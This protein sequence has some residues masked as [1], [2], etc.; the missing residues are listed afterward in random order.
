MRNNNDF[1]FVIIPPIMNS[2]FDDVEHRILSPLSCLREFDNHWMLEF[3]LPL[4]NKKDI[5]IT[6]DQNTVNIEAKLREEYFE[7]KLGNITKFEYFKKSTSLP[8]KINN[9]KTTAKFQKGRLVIKIPKKVIGHT[10]KI[11]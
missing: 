9:K 6:F 2:L 3:D 11:T 8:G 4:V 5:K 1:E 7:E 10:V